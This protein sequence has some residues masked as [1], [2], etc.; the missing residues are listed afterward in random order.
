M[1]LKKIIFVLI[2]IVLV[3]RIFTAVMLPDTAYTDTIYHLSIAKEISKTGAM[4]FNSDAKELAW[5]G[6]NGELPPQFFH[7]A[8]ANLFIASGTEFNFDLIAFFP[9]AVMLLQLGLVFL[10]CRLFFESYGKGS[11]LALIAFLFAA[12][13]PVFGIYSSVNYPDSFAALFVLFSVY[14]LV[15]FERTKNTAFL[16]LLPFAVSA[17]ALSKLTAMILLPVF[18]LAIVFYSVRSKVKHAKKIAVAIALATFLLSSFWY[19][20][21]FQ[22]QSIE[23]PELSFFQKFFPSNTSE[24][25]NLTEAGSFTL[26]DSPLN[27]PP[28]FIVQFNESFWFFLPYSLQSNVPFMGIFSIETLRLLFAILTFPI[29]AVTICGFLLIMFK[30]EKYWLLILLLFIFAAVPFAE[31]LQRIISMRMLLPVLPFFGIF[32]ARGLL[33]LRESK[34]VIGKVVLALFLLTVVYSL[35]FMVSTALY[36]EK[37]FAEARP[38]YEFIKTL[39][40]DS[41]LVAQRH[42]VRGI[43]FFGN[44]DANRDWD[45]YA[46]M[47]AEKLYAVLKGLKANSKVDYLLWTCSKNPWNPGALA[48]LESRKLLVPVFRSECSK[49]YEING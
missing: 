39:P 35:G 47:N 4:P 27:S 42:L 11:S 23:H 36:Y 2:A 26:V 25:K 10:I 40:E 18:L 3:A 12:I 38:A 41:R 30:R 16:F 34:P 31:R 24:I 49:V 43:I 21:D 33:G 48:E 7:V 32:F 29:L 13:Q 44:H 8:I 28:D 9:L 14:L 17:A 19:F 1:E 20:S 5:Q 6:I 46:A 15:K 37:S 45:E 22:R